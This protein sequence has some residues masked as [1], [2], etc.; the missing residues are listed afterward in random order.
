LCIGS[1]VWFTTSTCNTTCAME[2]A[3]HSAHARRSWGRWVDRATHVEDHVIRVHDHVPVTTL[4]NDIRDRC[5][6]ALL[7]GSIA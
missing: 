4:R 5:D 2:D 3:T 6:A 1:V 7:R